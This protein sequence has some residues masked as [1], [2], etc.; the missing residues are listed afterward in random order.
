LSL[1]RDVPAAARAAVAD[2][3]C[4]G[5]AAG[6]AADVDWLPGGTDY[7]LPD[8]RR[9]QLQH[10][11]GDDV[12]GQR[13]PAGGIVRLKQSNRFRPAAFRAIATSTSRITLASAVAAEGIRIDPVD[14]AG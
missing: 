10:R 3:L 7:R 9:P 13:S 5:A 11:G 6:G 12:A 4:R 14:R 1:S 2:L 8:Q